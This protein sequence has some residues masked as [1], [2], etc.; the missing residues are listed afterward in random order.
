MSHPKA[1]SPKKPTILLAKPN[2]VLMRMSVGEPS[3]KILSTLPCGPIQMIAVS[4]ATKKSLSASSGSDS[5]KACQVGR[6]AKSCLMSLIPC[7]RMM[8]DRPTVMMETIA[9]T[10][11]PCV[12]EPESDKL[13]VDSVHDQ[14]S[15]NQ[16]MRPT[17]P[18]PGR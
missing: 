12:W 1:A 13:S 11:R 6:V 3:G 4:Q 17:T 18:Q 7:H 14:Q 8:V 10:M 15:E 9:A 5:A 2:G 16:A